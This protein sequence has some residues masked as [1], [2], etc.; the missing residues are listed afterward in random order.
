MPSFQKKKVEI[1]FHHVSLYAPVRLI[2]E[3]GQTVDLHGSPRRPS[4]ASMA[5]LLFGRQ[6]DCPF[7]KSGTDDSAVVYGSTKGYVKKI[8]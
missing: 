2:E 6:C 4:G 1:E 8:G 7:R 5:E 3:I